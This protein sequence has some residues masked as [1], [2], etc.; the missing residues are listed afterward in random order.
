MLSGRGTSHLVT[1]QSND[2]EV[3]IV[4]ASAGTYSGA[5][6]HAAGLCHFAIKQLRSRCGN[7]RLLDFTRAIERG[8]DWK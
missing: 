6:V 8:R 7:F 1:P 5:P 4:H 3:L 2:R